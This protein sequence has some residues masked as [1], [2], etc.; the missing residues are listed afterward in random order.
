MFLQGLGAHTVSPLLCQLLSQSPK[1]IITG[2]PQDRSI[3]RAGKCPSSVNLHTLFGKLAQ[4]SIMAFR[5]TK[6][7]LITTIF[8][9]LRLL[10]LQDPEKC[11]GFFF[12]PLYHMAFSVA[13]FIGTLFCHL[14]HSSYQEKWFALFFFLQRF[15]LFALFI[16]IFP[17]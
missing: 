11:F 4:S 14:I 15:H 3:L 1:S 9:F 6:F 12:F 16:F 17:P 7:Y 8:Y 5:V 2:F 10:H 13:V